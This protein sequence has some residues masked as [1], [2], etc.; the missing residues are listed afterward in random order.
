MKNFI[1]LFLI[2][3]MA[4]QWLGSLFTISLVDAI[5]V[6]TTMTA[7]ENLMA[8]YLSERFQL[9]SDIRILEVD[10]ANYVRMGYSAPFIFSD[11]TN[12]E[13]SHYSI[14]NEDTKILIELKE[15]SLVDLQENMNPHIIYCFFPIFIS[16]L[17]P[18]E[19]ENNYL[20][21]QMCI[22]SYSEFYQSVYPSILLPPPNFLV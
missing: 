2:V 1:V 9:S 16:A 6:R 19:I 7:K 15:L 14:M 10:P 11:D 21:E 5:V 4:F 12:G 18:I 8:D 20:I 3:M 17:N 22:T 13:L